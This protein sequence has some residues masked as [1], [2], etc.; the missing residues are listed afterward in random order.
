MLSVPLS[1]D[2]LTVLMGCPRLEEVMIVSSESG[3]GTLSLT[4][5]TKMFSLSLMTSSMAQTCTSI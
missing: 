1:I 4:R 3:S 5:F 2:E